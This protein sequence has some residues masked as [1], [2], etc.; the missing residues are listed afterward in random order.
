M[1]REVLSPVALLHHLVQL[2]LTQVP[3]EG[4]LSAGDALPVNHLGVACGG[5]VYLGSE[6]LPWVVG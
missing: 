1:V 4:G 3:G 6:Q 5:K 2:C